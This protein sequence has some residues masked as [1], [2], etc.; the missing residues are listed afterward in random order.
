MATGIKIYNDAGTVQIDETYSNLVLI[1]KQTITASMSGPSIVYE[2]SV[3]ADVAAIAVQAYPETFIT[4]SAGVSGSTWTFRIT[5]FN[6]TGTTGTCTFTV[7]AFGK[8]PTPTETV[9]IKVYNA[10]GGLVFHSQ[11]KPL[12]IIA[13]TSNASGYT[14]PSGRSLAVMFLTLSLYSVVI[15]PGSG[16]ESDSL[17]VTGN[18]VEQQRLLVGSPAIGGINTTG[19]YAAVDVTNY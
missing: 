15:F 10:S 7:Y 19:T 8:P 6:I 11:F 3:T 2:Y 5:L 16:Y 4:K 12:R 18:V 9:G 13:V 14:G 1:D 17:R